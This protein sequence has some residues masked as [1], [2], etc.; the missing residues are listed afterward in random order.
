MTNLFQSTGVL[1]YGQHKLIV[2]ADTEISRYYRALI[3]KWI[4]TNPQKYPTHISVVRKEVPPNMDVW[5]KYEGKEVEFYYTSTIYFGTV[6]CWLNAFSERLEEIRLELGL[7]ISEKF[8][9]PPSDRW[10]KCFHITLGNFKHEI[11]RYI[12]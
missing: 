11:H 3:P 8:T 6:Y 10:K 4:N 9:Q 2:L 7:S 12:S 5:G 1:H